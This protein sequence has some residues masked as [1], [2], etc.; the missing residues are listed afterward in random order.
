[1]D[2]NYSFILFVARNLKHQKD[3]KCYLKYLFLVDRADADAN[4]LYQIKKFK[5]FIVCPLRIYF[6]L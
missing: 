3:N 5:F 6:V 4:I 1:M 2:Y